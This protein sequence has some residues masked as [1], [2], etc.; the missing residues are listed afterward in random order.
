MVG[1]S[2]VSDASGLISA[3]SLWAALQPLPVSSLPVV[4]HSSSITDVDSG[5]SGDLQVSRHNLASSSCKVLLPWSISSPQEVSS[6]SFHLSPAVAS[7]LLV[8]CCI[9]SVCLP[10]HPAFLS[11][12]HGPLAP[13][14]ILKLVIL[15]LFASQVI[16]SLDSTRFQLLG[17][18]SSPVVLCSPFPTL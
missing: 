4:F 16:S 3:R 17:Y 6:E 18:F 12:S 13:A 8:C 11:P 2:L 5:C 7:P 10:T 1:K 9:S 14:G 15:T